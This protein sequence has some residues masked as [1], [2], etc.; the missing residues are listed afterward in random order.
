MNHK[1]II[2]LT[3]ILVSLAWSS[4]GSAAEVNLLKKNGDVT[5]KRADE[6]AYSDAIEVGDT[7]TGGDSLKTGEDGFAALLFRDD[8]SI[9]KVRPK[10]LFTLIS[11][12]EVDAEVRE[13]RMERGKILLE[14]TGSGGVTYQLAT[15][16]SVASVKGTSFWTVSDGQG[17]DRFIGLDGTVEIVNT[18][19]G[20][21]VQLHE[22]ETVISSPSGSIMATPMIQSDPPA[23]PY[24]EG[25]EEGESEPMDES[26]PGGEPAMPEEPEQPEDTGEGGGPF[27]MSTKASVGAATIGGQVYNQIRIQPEFS[28]GK[29]G[30]GLDLALYVDQ[31]GNIRSE[32]WDDAGDVIDKVYYIR[33]GQP[34]Q[35]LYLRAGAIDNVS[36][37][38]GLLVNRYSNAIEY[39]GVRRVGLEYEVQ[40]GDYTVTG[41]L[42]NFR[43][44][45]TKDGP[46][47]F[48]TRVAYNPFW[49]VDV[50]FTYVVDGNQYLGATD[51]DGDGYPDPVD[52]FPEDGNLVNDSDNDGL[53]DWYIDQYEQ[54]DGNPPIYDKD[55]NN[56]NIIDEGYTLTQALQSINGVDQVPFSIANRFLSHAAAV[57]V[58]IPVLDWRYLNLHLFS[59]FAQILPTGNEDASKIDMFKNSWGATPFGML[60]QI[61]FVQTQFEYRYFQKFFASDMYNRTYEIDRVTT[62]RTEQGDLAFL[63]KTEQVL[64]RYDYTQKGFYGSASANL[65]D[66]VTL[67][68][69]YQDMF[70]GNDRLRSAYTELGLNTMF[71]PKIRTASA[72]IYKSNVNNLTVLRTPGTIMGYSFEYEIS[73]GAALRLNMQETYR[74]LNGNGEIED[75]NEVVRSTSIETVFSF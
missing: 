42:N 24:P 67:T 15:S 71:I 26:A 52:K 56:D 73:G 31:D 29:V 45:T 27:G 54:H 70:A 35:P 46:G 8:K 20:D 72:Y 68:A 63:T 21:T 5:I 60:M 11:Q 37:G 59:Q 61:G 51:T 33:Y 50:G 48:G 17:N 2:V 55:I 4:P 10:S 38:Y 36:L 57:D 3:G 16:T 28:I 44:F 13:I 41:F 69:S 75:G 53:P 32:D 14:V 39:P 74:D 6:V 65:F 23:D 64:N 7:V 47:L 34:G 43:E 30:V 62:G 9:I 18:V 19:S 40:F 66:M 12:E 25:I 58:G 22:N 49:K 1:I